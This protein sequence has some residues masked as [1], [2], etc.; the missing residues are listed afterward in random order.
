MESKKP[1]QKINNYEHAHVLAEAFVEEISKKYDL[2][3]GYIRQ[4]GLGENYDNVVDFWIHWIYVQNNSGKKPQTKEELIEILEKTIN[5]I[6]QHFV[7][8]HSK[9]GIEEFDKVYKSFVLHREEEH[10][11]YLRSLKDSIESSLR[12]KFYPQG[13]DRYFPESNPGE[14]T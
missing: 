12:K 8:E 13:T 1:E 9:D 3:T 2:K 10:Q 4:E 7:S 11:S 6:Y 5:E 14:I